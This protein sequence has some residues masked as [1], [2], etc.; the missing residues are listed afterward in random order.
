MKTLLSFLFVALLLVAPVS[1]QKPI[2]DTIPQLKEWWVAPS[3]EKGLGRYG[4]SYIPNFYHGRDAMA[5]SINNGQMETWLNRFPGDRENVFTWKG[6]GPVLQGDFNGD[7]ITDY[8]AGGYIYKGIQ[9]GEPPDTATVSYSGFSP[10]MIADVNHDGYDD[11]VWADRFTRYNQMS[12]KIFYGAADLSQMRA[13]AIPRE[14]VIDS[15]LTIEYS[16]MGGD[17]DIRF[18]A[19]SYEQVQLPAQSRWAGY[20]LLRGHWNKGDT[21]PTFEKLASVIRY[22]NKDIPFLRGGAVY[23]SKH[24]SNKFFIAK[25]YLSTNLNRLLIYNIT[26]D[27]FQEVARIN[28]NSV[29]PIILKYSIDQDS[30]EDWLLRGS[31]YS[32]FYSGGAELDTTFFAEYQSHCPASGSTNMYEAIGDVNGDGIHDIAVI[33]T[34]NATPNCFRIVLGQSSPTGVKE[35]CFDPS[36]LP[37]S[38]TETSPHP[39]SRNKNT[40]IKTI[41]PHVGVYILGL[42]DITGKNIS[43]LQREEYPAGQHDIQFNLSYISLSNGTYILRLSDDKGVLAGQRTIII[44]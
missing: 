22:D 8:F 14:P 20:V 23:T 36:A 30:V 31:T 19:F 28:R 42:F 15:T 29:I 26:S 12:M 10:N 24:S 21:F 33:S 1:A 40:V 37:F 35:P 25:E 2:Q 18:I 7:G 3:N 32:V 27:S 38:L 4:V 43:E 34:S 11:L 41:V 44:E 16:Y 5:V 17:G 39:V 9:N 13:I 6:G